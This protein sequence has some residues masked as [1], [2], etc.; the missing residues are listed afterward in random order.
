MF[1]MFFKSVF[2]Q[3]IGDWDVSN[4]TNMVG[5]FFISKFNQDISKWCVTKI[6]NEPTIFS[7]SS[8]LIDNYK[9]IW[10]YCPN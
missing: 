10:G 6:I 7:G 2:N 4:V 1:Q 3:P 8:Q 5:M 9:P